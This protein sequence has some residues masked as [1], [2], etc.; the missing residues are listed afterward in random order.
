[1]RPRGRWVGLASSAV[2]VVVSGCLDTGIAD[3]GP[4][5]DVRITYVGAAVSDSVGATV[6]GIEIFVSESGS[7]DRPLANLRAF[8]EARGEG[9]GAVEQPAARTDAEGMAGTAWRLGDRAGTCELRV[10]VLNAGGLQLA[11][12]DIEGE[13][14]SGQIET[15]A[16]IGEGGSVDGEGSLRLTGESGDGF[17]RVANEV[18]WRFRVLSGPLEALGDAFGAEGA[19]TLVPVGGVGPGRVAVETRWGDVVILDTCVSPGPSAATLR[20]QWTRPDATPPT[21][22]V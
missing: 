10:R 5:D 16:W 2:G 17:D 6:P 14:L 20:L 13:V 21:C 7:E 8:F 15:L 9:C 11:V 18:P 12:A 1:M 19:R 22:A 3:P 4:D